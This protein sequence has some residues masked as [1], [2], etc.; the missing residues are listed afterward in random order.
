MESEFRTYFPMVGDTD[1]VITQKAE[2]RRIATDAM[3]LNAGNQYRPYV[4]STPA[5]AAPG[6]ALTWDPVKKK[7]VNQ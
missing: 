7:W 4:P 3:R 2:A 6:G 1:A 5:A